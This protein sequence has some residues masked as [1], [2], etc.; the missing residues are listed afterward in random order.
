VTPIPAAIVE[1]SFLGA[2]DNLTRIATDVSDRNGEYRFRAIQ[3]G[4]YR[5]EVR[6]IGYAPTVVNLAI[7]ER[8][9]VR[10]S[11]ALEA[12]PVRLKP[13]DV[14]ARSNR[15]PTTMSWPV[16]EGP[17]TQGRDRQE[18][19][20]TMDSRVITPDD[21][22]ESV[23]LGKTDILRT[24]QMVPGIATKSDWTAELWT[25]GG[26]WD[27]TRV[28][29]DGVP[30]FNPLHTFGMFTAVNAHSVGL[31]RIHP[32]ARSAALGEGSAGL[33][34][35]ESATG[36]GLSGLKWMT[37]LS[38]FGG[39]VSLRQP[40]QR[41][42]GGFM[43]SGRTG[44]IGLRQDTPYGYADIAGRFDFALGPARFEGSWLWTG[45]D[46]RRFD[47][48]AH[49]AALANWGNTVARLTARLP[50]GTTRLSHTL[51]F[52]RSVARALEGG[53]N[54]TGGALN[55][56]TDNSIRQIM[57]RGDVESANGSRVA[58]RAGYEIKSIET[59]YFGSPTAPYAFQTFR[60]TLSY[61]DRITVASVWGETEW[62][63]LDRVTLRTGLRFER[64]QRAAGSIHAAPSLAGR[65]DVSEHLVFSLGYSRSFQYTQ[66]LEGSGAIIGPGLQIS[67][68]WLLAG[69]QVPLLRADIVTLGSEFWMT[70]EWSASVGVYQRSTRGM[71][72][73]DPRPG[74]RESRY[75]FARADNIARGLEISLRRV[76]A[77]TTASFSYTLAGSVVDAFGMT[78]PSSAERRHMLQAA[79]RSRL[80]RRILDG[81]V[82]ASF[83]TRVAS[84]APF[85][86]IFP[87]PPVC[88]S[89]AG[90]SPS[91]VEGNPGQISPR[92]QAPKFTI[93]GSE[94][95][96]THRASAEWVGHPNAW[97]TP[98]F[99][100]VDAQIEWTRA[101][102]GATV[103]A[104]LQVRNVLDRMNAVTYVR[105]GQPSCAPN[106]TAVMSVYGD[107][108]EPGIP[109]KP[110]LGIRL[111]Y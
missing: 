64:D 21:V 75:L 86:R 19:G 1:L 71:V 100:N 83:A 29:F 28:Y 101:F 54:G 27:Q 42:R 76:R 11:I 32:G 99:W 60:D 107:C 70:P 38:S 80:N 66:A 12:K 4:N 39:S 77:Q 22:V 95:L 14:V 106:G 16:V 90:T 20:L 57:V 45:D 7:T 68:V 34:E 6:R 52:G 35:M 24:I 65:F 13:L 110:I 63:P 48:P 3:P 89:S 104:Y 50:I 10:L 49:M 108:F 44:D 41:G 33:V 58:W 18:A 69:P 59:H 81:D 47:A 111:S 2:P 67:H 78:F 88:D 55:W 74:Y 103:Q 79:V 85:T 53:S 5:I 37:T 91:T 15:P 102:R 82:F 56:P 30:V 62:T 36:A 96:P 97:R 40:M 9:P 8:T 23:A 17:R 73:A 61:L 105:A 25:R 98:A 31:V 46:I 51:A 93:R 43:L 84:G 94:E 87:C 72:L 26:R 92:L 109:F